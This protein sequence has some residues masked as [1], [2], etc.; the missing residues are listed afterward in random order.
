MIYHYNTIFTGNSI[1]K[2]YNTCCEVTP[3][4]GWVCLW[5]ADVMTFHTFMDWGQFLDR[6]IRE[7]KD[8]ALFSCVTNRIGTHKQRVMPHQD[9]N[10]SMKFHRLEAERRFK[11][12]GTR[13]RKDVKTVSG[14]MMLFSKDTWKR[15]GGF[16]ETGMTGIDT[17]F[18]KA[19][20]DAGLGV[21]IIQ[22]LYVMHYYRLLEGNHNHLK[23]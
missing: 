4:D 1:G 7:N 16:P 3:D 8:T 12:Y 23:K 13:V 18:S 20:Y 19:V 11:M 21:G 5:D 10:P 2:F 6:V 22:G 9:P 15:V 17:A 14:L